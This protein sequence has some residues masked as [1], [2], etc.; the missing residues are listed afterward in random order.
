MK[1]KSKSYT[2]LFLGL[3]GLMTL[4]SC[5]KWLDVQPEDRFTKEQ[6]YNSA[7]SVEEVVNGLYLKMGENQLYGN[8]LTLTDLEVMSHRFR[9]GT[10]SGY[11]YDLKEHNYEQKDVK[12]SFSGIWTNMYAIIANINDMINVL[13]TVNNG[14][15]DQDKAQYIGQATGLRA[16][17]HFDLL[18]LYGPAYSDETKGMSAIPYVNKLSTD[19]QPFLSSEMVIA[20]I[21]AD[22]KKAKELLK[23]DPILT[24]DV[25]FKNNYFNYYAVVALEARVQ[26]WAGNK[27]A[28]LA[29]AKQV[30]AAQDKFPWVTHQKIA[31]NGSNPDRKFFTEVIFSVFND[32]LYDIQRDYFGSN[33]SEDQILATGSGNLVSNIYENNESDYRYN[34]SW[35][36]ASTGMGYR[37]FVKFDDIP[38]VEILSRF[39]VPLIRISEMYYIAA[40]STTDQTE[41]LNYLNNVRQHRNINGDISNYETLENEL[42]K[43]YMKEFYGEGQVWFYYKR[44]QKANI[45]SVNTSNLSFIMT[46]EDYIIPIP[47]A[48]TEGR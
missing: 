39:M 47:L 46:P 16:F 22:I 19:I 18:R 32:K 1:I 34:F 35:P 20:N 3:L 48:E 26:Q 6:V 14:L 13:P 33:L 12:N 4:G 31:G 17:I 8:K 7:S 40:E 45:F 25:P 37:T 44:K 15:T 43:E 36:F 24:A 2:Y 9:I 27:E 21:L 28:A 23:N 11:Y 5:Q 10:T 38:D 30:I 41:A 29:A 42:T